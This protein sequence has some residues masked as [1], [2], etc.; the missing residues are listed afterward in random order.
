MS[1]DSLFPSDAFALDVPGCDLA[2]LKRDFS[3]LNSDQ[4]GAVMKSISA[5]DFSIIQGLPGTGKSATIA[6][7]TRL[8]VSRG[9]RVLLTSY[10]HSAVDNLMCKL[11]ES[12]VI[13]TPSSL[14]QKVPDPMVRIGRDSACHPNVQ[15]LLAQNIAC[16]SERR[17]SRDSSVLIDNPSVDYLHKVISAARIVGVSACDRCTFC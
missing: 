6:F 12:G 2:R 17:D 16:E 5:E 3:K 7:L 9:K 8:L 4:Q 15:T 11:M 13:Q 1:V 10:T 14:H